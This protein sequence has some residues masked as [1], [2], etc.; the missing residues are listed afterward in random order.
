MFPLSYNSPI[1]LNY[2]MFLSLIFV[3]SFID[4]IQ[5]YTRVLRSGGFSFLNGESLG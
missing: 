5:L 1:A 2:N 3:L 4:L